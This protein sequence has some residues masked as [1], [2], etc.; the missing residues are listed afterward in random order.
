MIKGIEFL[1][2]NGF[3]LIKILNK[4]I[5]KKYFINEN[6]EIKVDFLPNMCKISVLNYQRV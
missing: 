3:L 5:R 2:A 4:S 1:A 6:E